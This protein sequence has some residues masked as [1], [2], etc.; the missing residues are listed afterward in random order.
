MAEPIITPVDEPASDG[1]AGDALHDLSDITPEQI[2]KGEEWGSEDEPDF[3]ID[4]RGRKLYIDEMD[5]L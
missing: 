3:I 2:A 4:E 1:F 5:Q